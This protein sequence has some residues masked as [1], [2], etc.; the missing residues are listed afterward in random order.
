MSVVANAGG[1]IGSGVVYQYKGKR[2]S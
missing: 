2:T 1:P